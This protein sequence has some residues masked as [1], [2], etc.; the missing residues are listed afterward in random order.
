MPR[1]ARAP[2]PRRPKVEPLAD[3]AGRETVALAS[4]EEFA[5]RVAMDLFLFM[6][7]PH[8]LLLSLFST[9]SLSML[10]LQ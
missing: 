6:A 2:P 1:P 5:R 3:I 7:R 8:I 4:K 10:L 9:K